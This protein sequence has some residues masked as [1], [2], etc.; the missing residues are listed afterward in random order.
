MVLYRYDDHGFAS[1]VDD[2]GGCSVDIRII[3]SDFAVIKETPCGY[4]IWYT[5]CH[6]RWVSKHSRKRFA[7]AS[8]E[9]AWLSFQKRKDRQISIL[10]ERLK[11]AEYARQLPRPDL[12]KPA[13]TEL[14][15]DQL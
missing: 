13:A 9:E 5:S 3:L 15:L 7:H 2:F 14:V 11:R 1:L 10:S 8:K 4:W 12:P 6:K